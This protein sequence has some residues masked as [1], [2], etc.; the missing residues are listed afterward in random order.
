MS[1]LMNNRVVTKPLKTARFLWFTVKPDR[2][3]FKNQN[4]AAH[5]LTRLDCPAAGLAK[6]VQIMMI[7]E[8]F[9]LASEYKRESDRYI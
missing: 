2:S 3:D 5:F 1:H 9:F 4:T 6:L 8:A 7:R